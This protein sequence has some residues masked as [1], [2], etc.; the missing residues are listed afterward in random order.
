MSI[1]TLPG[2]A[3]EYEAQEGPRAG[4]LRRVLAAIFESR[5]LSAERRI[6]AYLEGQSEERLAHL[7]FS[8]ADLSSIRATA[9][10]RRSGSTF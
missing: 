4:L 5:R 10:Q 7:G 3:A 9:G 1:I 2:S 6:A 8:A